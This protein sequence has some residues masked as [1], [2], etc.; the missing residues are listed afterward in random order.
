MCYMIALSIIFIGLI[1]ANIEDEEVRPGI[2]HVLLI[3]Y[4]ILIT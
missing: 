2:W 3:H 4:M 1:L